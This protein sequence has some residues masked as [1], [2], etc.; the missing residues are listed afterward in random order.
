MRLTE[1]EKQTLKHAA[2]ACFGSGTQVRLFGSR[3]DDTRRGGDI[4]L[5]VEST[6]V[7]PADIAQAHTRFLSQ[8]YTRMG[9]QKVDVVIDFPGR[10]SHPPIFQVAH[11]E[12][13]LL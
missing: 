13:I 1:H 7:D 9:E 3:A 2:L 4:D 5:L 11:Q 8:I 10:R 12:G 6:L